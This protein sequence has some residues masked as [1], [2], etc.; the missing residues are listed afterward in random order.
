VE[1]YK[2][3]EKLYLEYVKISVKSY[4]IIILYIYLLEA[5]C[6]RQN[7]VYVSE[8]N[9]N[10]L[11]LEFALSLYEYYK[12][13]ITNIAKNVT[14]QPIFIPESFFWNIDN[15]NDS[16]FVEQRQQVNEKSILIFKG[17]LK[18]IS[19]SRKELIET[20][21]NISRLITPN[22]SKNGFIQKCNEIVETNKTNI[23]QYTFRSSYW[24]EKT[25]TDYD[26]HDSNDFIYNMQ[27]VVKNA[28][29]DRII[30]DIDTKDFFDWIVYNNN[31]NSIKNSLYKAVADGLNRQLDFDES[32]TTNPYTELIDGILRFT[33]NKLKELVQFE[34]D[35]NY[36]L[37]DQDQIST[38]LLILQKTL[39]IKFIIF[40][41]FDRLEQ[42]LDVGDMVLYRNRPTRIVSIK[43][44]NGRKIYDLY[45]GYTNIPNIAADHVEKYDANILDTFRIYCSYNIFTEDD[46][47]DD[48]MYLIVVENENNE[49]FIK[50]VQQ[51][52][53]PII[54]PAN[55][56]PI[57][58]QYL[59]FNSCSRLMLDRG[60]LDDSE[61]DDMGLKNIRE[62]L[63]N[64]KIMRETHIEQSNIRDFIQR[65]EN[66][67][68]RKREELAKIN[69]IK[70]KTLTQQAEIGLL[71]EEIK[72][73]SSR[74]GYL[75]SILETGKIRNQNPEQNENQN[76]LYGNADIDANADINAD[77]NADINA[78][79]NANAN[80]DINSDATSI[81]GGASTLRT[82]PSEQYALHNTLNPQYNQ[83]M[84]LQNPNIPTNIVYLPR[85]SYP[86]PYPY[87]NQY[88]IPY[89]VSQNKAKDQKSKLS[90]YIT[91]E[92]EL[93]PGTSASM[94]QKSVVKC[95][96]TFERIR[97]AWADIFGFQYR[98]YPMVESYAYNS[99]KPKEPNS[100]DK[101]SKTEKNRVLEKRESEKK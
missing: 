54:F 41:M 63:K 61:I 78:D 67:I 98:P 27:R 97:E 82:R 16:N 70:N 77:A 69:K 5:L 76:L 22:V 47:I 62:N 38:I 56:I 87:Q 95:Q 86:Y 15:L 46:N 30:D 93:F 10:H 88:Y 101:K 11:N 25:I 84:Y 39:K 92:L 80:A 32:E 35:N 59:I 3:F 71:K 49:R 89:N 52:D 36:M 4:D 20:C 73:L 1:E 48:Y 43:N 79:A 19:E 7:R 96:S 24:L 60:E 66:E 75:K 91:I 42:E 68:D 65:I 18:S 40:E 17:R 26:V 29:Y 64:F 94:L 8:E 90:F 51:T 100:E 53:K 23:K 37:L 9:V 14:G 45:N 81:I 50:L 33:D 74:R 21:E 34:H 31:G 72:D 99:E 57:F 55:D 28:W 58:I 6:L 83:S 12:T 85:Q 13:I 2:Q 44:E